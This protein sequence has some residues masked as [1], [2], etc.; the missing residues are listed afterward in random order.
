MYALNSFLEFADIRY[1]LFLQYFCKQ[2]FLKQV[3]KFRCARQFLD[4]TWNDLPKIN[5]IIVCNTLQLLVFALL[6]IP[7]RYNL[8]KC[9]LYQ[10]LKQGR[11]N[12]VFYTHYKNGTLTSDDCLNTLILVKEEMIDILKT[13]LFL[14]P[15]QSFEI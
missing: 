13:Y 10:R 2:C 9:L 14:I 1:R 5:K 3:V 6:S 8:L 11:K 4:D 12:M 15:F 7:F